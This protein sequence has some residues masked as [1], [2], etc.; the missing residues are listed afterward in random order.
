LGLMLDRMW[1]APS[2]KEI[3]E[4]EYVAYLKENNKTDSGRSVTCGY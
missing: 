4:E 2:E 1:E 3:E